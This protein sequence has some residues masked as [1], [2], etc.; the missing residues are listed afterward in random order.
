MVNHQTK[1]YNIITERKTVHTATKRLGT[2]K[3]KKMTKMKNAKSVVRMYIRVLEKTS[4]M[5]ENE[6]PSEDDWFEGYKEG[7][8]K[9]RKEAMEI[10]ID[11]LKEMEEKK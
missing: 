2:R 10:L 1:A 5:Y 9:A 11:I 7:A 8:S 4:T 3:E 6:K